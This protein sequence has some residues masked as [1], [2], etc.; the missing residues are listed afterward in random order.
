MA[1]DTAYNRLAVSWGLAVPRLLRGDHA[2]AIPALARGLAIAREMNIQIWLPPFAAALGY[3][4]A[5][6]GRVTEG[7]TLLEEALTQAERRMRYARGVWLSWLSEA[8]LLAGRPG[9]AIA[10]AQ[11][12]SRGPAS[13]TSA[14][15]RRGTCARWPRPRRR[16]TRPTSPRPTACAARP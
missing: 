4:H 1:L 16:R 10:A 8:Y 7:L 14:L 13:A 5:L 6:A 12:V 3:A 15:T 11:R 9:D 2:D